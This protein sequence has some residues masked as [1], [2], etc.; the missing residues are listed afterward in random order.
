MEIR[1]AKPED[2]DELFHLNELFGNTT[3]LETIKE[4][5][6]GNNREIVCIAYADGISAGYCT[7][8][9]MNSMCYSEKRVDIEALYVRD[10]YRRQGIGES[11]ISCLEKEAVSQGIH[12]FHIITHSENIRALSL[13]KRIGY[14]NTGEIL[15][16]K[17][18]N[19]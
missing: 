16:D 6:T 1:R 15:L 10:E 17:T 5:L 12:H 9:I 13:Y 8:L 3:T 19:D 4:S 7:G 2:A 11:L 14:T 18:I